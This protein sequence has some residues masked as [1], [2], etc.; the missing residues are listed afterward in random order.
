M[1]NLI[2]KREFK[3]QV[4]EGV[5]SGETT[6][7]RTIFGTAILF[8]TPSQDF[9]GFKE[10]IAPEAFTNEDIKRFDIKI[11]FQHNEQFIP[12]ARSNKGKGTLKIT[13]DSVGVHF[14][15]DAKNTATGEEILQAIRAG[16][17]DKMSFGFYM[18]KEGQ[19][20]TKNIDGSYV[21][22]IIKF[23]DVVEF[24]I[25]GTTA[26]YDSA[27]VNSRA[28]E[29]AKLELVK[30]S[31]DV[32]AEELTEV[33]PEVPEEPTE[34]PVEEVEPIETRD[35]KDLENAKLILEAKQK[36]EEDKKYWGKYEDLLNKYIKLN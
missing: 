19:K 33:T 11:L 26:A 5:I 18:N 36:E 3:I 20:W 17:I 34:T 24:S 29:Q 30:V 15:F 27:V 28:L 10:I 13:I 21:R 4:R 14:E 12:L 2:E 22:T 32:P 9:G 6:N 8:N 35:N 31:V 25:L 23:L 1:D 16:D 7:S